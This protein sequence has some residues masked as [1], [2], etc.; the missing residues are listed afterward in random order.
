MRT[1]EIDILIKKYLDAE[2][3]LVEETILRDYFNNNNNVDEHL[4][5]YKMMFVHFNKKE[6]YRKP[7]VKKS[8]GW[9]RIAASV[10]L[11]IGMYFGFEAK[12]QY[13]IQTAYN[14]T[15]EAFNLL[16]TNLNKGAK[17]FAYIGEFNKTTNKIFKQ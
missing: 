11:L 7:I 5:P 14:E 4:L 16:G 3:T 12:Q 15:K 13:E 17:G 8:F 6:T 2:T 1:H 10:V 9:I